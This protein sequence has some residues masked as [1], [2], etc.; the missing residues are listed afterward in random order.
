LKSIR[1]WNGLSRYGIIPL[2]GEAD[3][4]GQRMLCDL[5]SPGE[6]L[7]CELLGL[8]GVQLNDSYNGRGAIG[9][10]ML[11]FSLFNDLAT[12]CLITVDECDEAFYVLHQDEKQWMRAI[13]GVFGCSFKEG[14][15][16]P[17]MYE[18]KA[19][20]DKHIDYLISIQCLIRRIKIRTGQPGVGTR[21]FHAMSGRLT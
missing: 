20:W 5:T 11:P 18:L 10:I 8:K 17:E 19:D 14:H 12:W 15:A 21:A 9:S 7:V 1:D 4:T 2:T 13:R 3:R 16:D 6:T